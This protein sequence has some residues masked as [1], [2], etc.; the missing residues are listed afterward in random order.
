VL[1]RVWRPP[2]RLVWVGLPALAV[3][4]A[5][6]VQPSVTFLVVQSGAIGAAL[7]VLIAVMQRLVE[8]RRPGPAFYGEPSGRT[9]VPGSGSGLSRTAGVGS[10]D[11][12]AIRVRTA[13]TLDYIP[14]GTTPPPGQAGAGSSTSEHAAR[15]GPVP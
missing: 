4:V 12:T 8:G 5:S 11:S 1:V 13:S 6:L 15:G 10:D 7:A 14:A 9:P 3:A 2:P